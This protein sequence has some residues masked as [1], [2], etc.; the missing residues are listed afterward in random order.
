[1]MKKGFLTFAMT[2]IFLMI[3]LSVSPKTIDIEP[4]NAAKE[5]LNDLLAIVA[6]IYVDDDAEPGWYNAYNVKTI[7]E[8]IDNASIGDTVFVYNGTY[9][10]NLVVDKPINFTS[11][12]KHATIINGSYKTDVVKI[13]ADNVNITGFCVKNSGQTKGALFNISS[14]N[15]SIKNIITLCDEITQN[16][17]AFMLNPGANGN[18]ISNNELYNNDIGFD[19]QSA[20]NI[21]SENIIRDCGLNSIHLYTKY[22]NKDKMCSNNIIL[23][24]TIFEIGDKIGWGYGIWLHASRD[25]SIIGNNVKNKYFGIDLKVTSHNN[26]INK[27]NFS[28]NRGYGIGI[29]SASYCNISFNNVTNNEGFGIG[30]SYRPN[31]DNVVYHNNIINNGL[32]SF[33]R[34]CYNIKWIENYWSDWIGLKFPKLSFLPY[35]IP[36]GTRLNGRLIIPRFSRSNFD[37]H[38]AAEPYDI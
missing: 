32:N 31:H 35:W 17:A 3:S 27:N 25:N 23:N 11:E 14:C 5:N 36:K 13:L 20:H 38:P 9:V 33:A 37:W 2:C 21:I 6:D 26:I 15:N 10:E 18:T 30:F 8:G 1:M 4:Q 29:G 16:N 28:N 19:V 22:E 12:S 34:E 7:Q 24:N